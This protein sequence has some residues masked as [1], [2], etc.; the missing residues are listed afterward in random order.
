MPI[1]VD[2]GLAIAFSGVLI[3]V[4]QLWLGYRRAILENTFKIFDR[5]QEKEARADRFEVGRILSDAEN[6]PEGFRGISSNDRARLAGIGSTFG[7]AG[8]LARKGKVDLRLLVEFWGN[9][10]LYN[11]K[12]LQPYRD[13]RDKRFGSTEGTS[14]MHFDW[15]AQKAEMIQK[16]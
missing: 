16:G 12:R 4:V 10:I 7:F 6:S 3:A 1:N 15:L 11:H 2:P 13:Y 9:S 14:W 5:L 8:L